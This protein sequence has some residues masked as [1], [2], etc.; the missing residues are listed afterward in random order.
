MENGDL[1]PTGV[2]HFHHTPDHCKAAFDTINK[3]RQNVQVSAM[4]IIIL[5]FLVSSEDFF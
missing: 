2:T 1:C 4:I 5:T 3:M